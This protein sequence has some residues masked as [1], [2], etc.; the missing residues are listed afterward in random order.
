MPDKPIGKVTHFF[1][2]ISVAVI[3]LSK[4]AKLKAGDSIKIK[5]H[6]T[7]FEQ[8]VKSLQIDHKDVTEV[9]GGDDFGIKVD[10]PV[11]EG[12]QVFMA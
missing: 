9:K 5:G 7:D 6:S 1:D 12:D 10:Q 3:N 2:A 8:P 4:G 11:R